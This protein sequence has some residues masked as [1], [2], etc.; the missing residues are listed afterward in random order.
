M[1]PR[2]T[3][4]GG[5]PRL[6]IELRERESVKPLELFFDLV[7]VLGFTQCTALMV[8]EP[9]WSGIGR[10][11][12]VL[13]VLWWA[14][15]CY[16]WLTSLVEPEEG[17]VRVLMLVAMTGL[18]VVALCVPEAFGDH[19]LAFAIAYG[20]V[21]FGHIVL[22]LFVSRDSP[23]RRLVLRFA[24]STAVAVGLLVGASFLDG[25][26]QVALWVLAI[27]VDWV[28]PAVFGDREWRLVPAHFAERHNLIDHHRSR[29]VDR[30]ARCRRRRRSDRRRHRRGGARD[31]VGIGTLVDLLRRRRDRDRAAP[32]AGN[33]RS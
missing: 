20:V 28:L 26:V 19:A 27:V 1:I 2:S 16:A 8:A 18:L 5:G 12:L 7:F 32:G 23:M 29:R 10:G 4:R 3:H 13:A 14:W 9:T 31:G 21:R 15:G 30:G 33:R 6:N 17:S 24:M 22:Y 11:M 25:S